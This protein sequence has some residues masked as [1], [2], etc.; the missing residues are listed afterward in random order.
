MKNII[1][2]SGLILLFATKMKAK[3]FHSINNNKGIRPCDAQG[4]GNFDA[5]RGGRTHKGVDM[6]VS[7]NQEVT[8]PFDCKINRYGY[9]YATDLNYRLI[10]IIGTGIK[11][12]YKMKIMYI[13]EIH[14]V[15]TTIKRGQVLCIADDITKKYGSSMTRHVHV[16]LYKNN[17]LIDPTPFLI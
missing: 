4:C 7:E 5:G 3:G 11:A 8:A 1:I 13:K 12:A 10:E 9:P 16:E 14:S 2:I 15:G 6:I 17:Q